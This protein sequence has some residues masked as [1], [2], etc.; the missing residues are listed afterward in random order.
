MPHSTSLGLNRAASLLP[1]GRNSIKEIPASRIVATHWN[2]CAS[3]F[4][5]GNNRVHAC[6]PRGERNRFAIDEIGMHIVLDEGLSLHAASAVTN[7]RGN[8]VERQAE[9]DHLCCRGTAHVM[10]PESF[11]RQTVPTRA[12]VLADQGRAEIHSTL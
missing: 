6:V 1:L 7:D 4:L 9:L 5:V 2:D 8:D 11:H 10:R 3:R 12:N